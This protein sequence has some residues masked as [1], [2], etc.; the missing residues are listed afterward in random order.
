MDGP[1]RDPPPELH[2]GGGGEGGGGNC[3]GCLD[4]KV[5]QHI[6]FGHFSVLIHL[7]V[8]CWCTSLNGKELLNKILLSTLKVNLHANCVS[9][10]VYEITA[11]TA[12]VP[13]A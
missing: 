11:T 2:N 5:L 9:L 3:G 6:S 1:T 4:R 7:D 10:T 8:V 13:R 12:F